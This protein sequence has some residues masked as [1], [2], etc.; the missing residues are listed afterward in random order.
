MGRSNMCDWEAD[1]YAEYLLWVAAEKARARA[2]V[3]PFADPMPSEVIAPA[4]ER[5]PT[6]AEA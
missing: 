1:E 2:R 4:V 5:V 3:R 6:A